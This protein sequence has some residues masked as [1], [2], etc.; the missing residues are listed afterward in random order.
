MTSHQDIVE[1]FE[2]NIFFE[3]EYDMPQEIARTQNEQ[4]ISQ[5][6]SNDG[7]NKEVQ[8]KSIMIAI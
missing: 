2:E 5:I 6:E 1:D 3:K 4:D 7:T 8:R